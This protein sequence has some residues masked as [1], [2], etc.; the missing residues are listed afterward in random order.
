MPHSS[1]LILE[2]RKFIDPQQRIFLETAWQALENAGCDV[3]RYGG[4]VGVFAGA[5]E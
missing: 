2:K 1:G 3:D 5:N 4:V